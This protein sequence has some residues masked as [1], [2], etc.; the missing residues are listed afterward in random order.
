[1]EDAG[2]E[3]EQIAA[4]LVLSNYFRTMRALKPGAMEAK[5][6]LSKLTPGK[7]SRLMVRVSSSTKTKA[8]KPQLNIRRARERLGEDAYAECLDPPK[9]TEPTVGVRLVK[10]GLDG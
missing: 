7:H 9:R 2:Y 5:R 1:M 10:D 6:T 3:D 8:H 4:A